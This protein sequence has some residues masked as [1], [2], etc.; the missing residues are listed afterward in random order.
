MVKATKLKHAILSAAAALICLL[1]AFGLLNGTFAV[2]AADEEESF[3]DYPT[4]AVSVTNSQFT[5]EG[6][7]SPASPSNWT[8][9]GRAGTSV[10]GI[11]DLDPAD[12]R[13][14]YEDYKLDI[15]PE[16]SA[17]KY[18]ETPFGNNKYPGTSTN[19][20]MINT[21]RDE[22]VYGYT[23]STFT[24]E[25]NRYYSVSVYV[26]TGD[27]ATGTGASIR[28]EGVDSGKGEDNELIFKNID[29]VDRLGAG[30]ALTEDNDYGF[31]RYTFYIGTSFVSST[32]S[33]NLSAGA[34]R[35][36][37]TND[38]N[39]TLPADGYAF[40]A[41]VEVNELSPM[42]F[43]DL[44][45]NVPAGSTNTL[46]RDLN[47]DLTYLTSEPLAMSD[48][49]RI[50]NTEDEA[51]S[52]GN[53][54]AFIYNAESS[55]Y[56]DTYNFDSDP[57]SPN[58]K[59]GNSTIFGLT[60][61]NN[62]YDEYESATIGFRTNAEYTVRRNTYV[63]FSVW[64]K[65]QDLSGSAFIKINTDD[66]VRND[67]DDGKMTANSATI[68]SGDGV[69]ARYG[70]TE[71]ALYVK[72][73]SL[74]DYT[75]Y[76]E[77][78]L[79]T[80][81]STTASGIVM[82]SEIR[83]DE[84]TYTEYTDN[85]ASGTAVSFD[86]TFSDTG[87]TN[88]RF[89]DIGDY[90]EYSYPL[91]PASWTYYTPDTVTTTGFS[92]EAL[93]NSE[94]VVSGVIPSD[95]A[96]IPDENKDYPLS[97]VPDE[98]GNFLMIHYGGDDRTAAGYA[99]SSLTLTAGTQYT[100]SVNLLTYDISGYG[101]NL[102][103]KNGDNN[104][105]ATMENIDTA[106]EFRQYDFLVEAGASDAT[107]TLEI[108]L[109]LNDRIDN[110]QK[111]A[112]GTVFV[113]TVSMASVDSSVE[114]DVS[115]YEARTESYY[116]ALKN[117]S[118]KDLTY[119]AYTFAEETFDAYDVYS[120]DAV[121][122]AYN[123]TL[124]AGSTDDVTYGIIRTNNREQTNLIPDYFE[125]GDTENLSS[126]MLFIRNNAATYSRVEWNNAFSLTENTY[127]KLT[128]RVKVD[129][130]GRD[131]S[132]PDTA[133]GAGIELTGTD[134]KFED[135]RST[136]LVKDATIDNEY[137]RE[138]TF[139]I[140]AETASDI[141]LAFTL[142]GNE[143]TNENARGILYVTNIAIE[144]IGNTEYEDAVAAMADYKDEHDEDDPYNM[145]AVISSDSTDSDS[146][147]DTTD[148]DT[149]TP[150]N[151]G[152]Q[153]WLIPS[154][155]FAVAIVIAIVGFSVRKFIDKR[156][157]RKSKVKTAN[158]DR[159]VSLNRQQPVKKDETTGRVVSGTE[160]AFGTFDDDKPAAPRPAAQQKPVADVTGPAPDKASD[161]SA[162]V[163]AP[164][165]ETPSDQTVQPAPAD[166]TAA[167]TAPDESEPGAAESDAAENAGAVSADTAAEAPAAPAPA[168]APA[169]T[170]AAPAPAAPAAPEKPSVKAPVTKPDAYT[171]EFED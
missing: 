85:N 102:V 47:E 155:L 80:D 25:A 122:T 121:K 152:I 154:I 30:T 113:S 143:F 83:A 31:V 166:E 169:P 42:T 147:D 142:G 35:T 50:E 13:N 164:A 65:T 48:F 4:T 99:S 84:I 18:P 69:E 24:L 14:N 6:S 106:G 168:P 103:L 124:T 64:V 74:Q 17:D 130:E 56:D 118:A 107:V 37:E 137:Y 93:D 111:L 75:V 49:S 52:T 68:S 11:V 160:D 139:Y 8:A 100:I 3:T 171:D 70:W 145:S 76:V 36:D 161:V 46:V 101:A 20:L 28:L 132:N 119:T 2:R 60:T 29:T 77:L 12:Y 156:A 81:A 21:N 92:T 41:N 163:P 134:A 51:P 71:Y 73:S 22:T 96:S 57:L 109:G 159:R 90:D 129:F 144:E 63:R 39:Y 78:W 23:S 150:D 127:H 38:I 126:G 55:G 87:V 9:T 165:D 82:F 91:A 128:V 61:Y 32:A 140:H 108:W 153:W 141:G 67:T 26:K 44:T 72:G 112:S 94:D 86:P 115:A 10:S 58:G 34:E 151:G 135:I 88:G 117:G 146:G 123:W 43:L 158:Y 79:G 105:I 5:D 98:P 148:T 149:T 27:F 59:S 97:F 7:G 110:H 162:D 138:F 62:R 136:A 95:I 125:R 114:D 170:P 89:Y 54:S 53:A 104:V 167:T 133:I 15:Y 19:V 66:T 45:E 16:Y 1:L 33:L 116:T 131:I 40:F 120:A 157:K